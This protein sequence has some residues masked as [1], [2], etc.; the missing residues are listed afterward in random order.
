MKLLQKKQFKSFLKNILIVILLSILISL[1]TTISLN[2]NFLLIKCFFDAIKIFF[3][4]LPLA[5]VVKRNFLFKDGPL[6]SILIILYYLILV[7][8]INFTFKEYYTNNLKYFFSFLSFINILLLL[9]SHIILLKYVITD[10]LKKK[11]KIVISDIGIV[12]TTY[13]TIAISFGLLYTLL[14][15]YSTT[16][17]FYGISK[18]LSNFEFYFK[19][20]Y[21]SFIT[22]STVG[23]GDVYPLTFIGQFLVLIEIITGIMLTNVILGLIIGSGILNTK[24]RK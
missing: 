17:A 19:H 2:K 21:F 6:K 16:P 22:I 9:T 20:I 8:I 13:I 18:N 11:R 1:I 10:F 15:L 24:D 12:I 7:P 23:Y 5:F 3:S 14:S 4:V